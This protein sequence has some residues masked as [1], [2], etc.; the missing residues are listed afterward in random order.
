[1]L[2]LVLEETNHHYFYDGYKG[3]KIGYNVWESTEQP[4]EF[5]QR[6]KDYD[7]IWVPSK[8]QAEIVLLNRELTQPS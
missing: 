4:E 8:W 2:N 7:Q 5:F 1:M 6:L 3:P